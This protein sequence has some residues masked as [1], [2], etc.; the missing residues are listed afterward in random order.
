MAQKPPVIVKKPLPVNASLVKSKKPVAKQTIA[1]IKSTQ[2]KPILK[3]AK[4]QVLA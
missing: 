1:Q 4:K 2:K 3:G